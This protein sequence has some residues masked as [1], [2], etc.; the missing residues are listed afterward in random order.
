ML[1]VELLIEE[2][3]VEEVLE[4]IG[5]INKQEKIIFPSCYLFKTQDDYYIAHFKEM[6][7]EYNPNSFDNMVDS[8]I[9]RRNSI[10]ILLENWNFLNILS[11]EHFETVF[12]TILPLDMKSSYTIHHKFRINKD[13]SN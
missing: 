4:R 3:K 11:N 5:I 6:I 13:E 1:K 10:A 2:Y 9:K 7:R 12:V 8:D